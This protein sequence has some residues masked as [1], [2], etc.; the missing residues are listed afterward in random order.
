LFDSRII[1]DFPEIFAEFRGKQFSL[2]WRGRRDGFKAKDFQRRCD[3]H[4]N[5]LTVILDTKG[6]IF[7]GFTPLEW[8]LG[9]FVNADFSLKSFLF[10]LKNPHNIPARRFALNVEEG[11]GYKAMFTSY[12]LVHTFVTFLFSITAMQASQIALNLAILTSTTPEWTDKSF[13]RVH[14]VSKSKKSKSSRL[15]PQQ[16][17]AQIF[18]FYTRGKQKS[19]KS[20]KKSFHGGIESKQNKHYSGKPL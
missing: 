7:G 8:E 14:I 18:L 13:S 19:K 4:S 2:L 12:K 11:A 10:T 5:T 17:I 6:N 15:Q 1:S 3:G 16:R 20:Q 9:P